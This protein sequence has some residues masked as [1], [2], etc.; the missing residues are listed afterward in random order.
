LNSGNYY[1]GYEIDP[2]DNVPE[3][4]E[5][6][7]FCASNGANCIT[8]NITNTTIGSQKFTYPILFVHGWTSDSRTWNEFTDEADLFYGW[9]YGGRLDYCLNP[10]E[11][12][13]TMI[14][15]INQR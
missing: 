7:L 1:I 11:Y 14:I 2:F 15:A 3:T 12:L 10:D 8:F 4:D 13:L 9:T 5:D 6:N